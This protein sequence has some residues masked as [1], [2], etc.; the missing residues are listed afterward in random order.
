MGQ[1]AY[2]GVGTSDYSLFGTDAQKLRIDG[3]GNVFLLKCHKL[4][5]EGDD[6]LLM[7]LED[8]TEELTM[9]MFEVV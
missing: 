7:L 8:F 5:H 6:I 9:A 1:V 2:D 3:D 4:D